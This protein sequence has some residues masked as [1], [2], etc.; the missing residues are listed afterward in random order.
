MFKG[1]TG[2]HFDSGGY[3]HVL[4]VCGPMCEVHYG[5][6]SNPP[7]ASLKDQEL[8]AALDSLENCACSCGGCQQSIAIIQGYLN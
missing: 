4:D 1:T 7:R 5:R 3:R 8:K 6:P 2:H